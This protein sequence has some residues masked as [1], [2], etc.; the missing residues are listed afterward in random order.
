M[1][2]RFVLVWI[3]RFPLF[4]DGWEGLRFMIVAFPGLFAYLFCMGILSEANELYIYALYSK[5]KLH[6][7]F[8]DSNSDGS[9]T[10][11]DSN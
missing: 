7:N 3:C 5:K 10:V 6:L 9:F 11:A 4:L 1:F 8:N 2:D